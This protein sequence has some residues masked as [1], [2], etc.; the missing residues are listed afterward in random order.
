MFLFVSFYNLVTSIEFVEVGYR[1]K[2]STICGNTIVEASFEK[3]KSQWAANISN[4]TY[5]AKLCK[6]DAK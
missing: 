4:F 3:P 2:I 5:V 6:I 1:L